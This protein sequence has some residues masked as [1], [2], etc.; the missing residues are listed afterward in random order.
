MNCNCAYG[1]PCQFNA[2]PT[3]R[4]C[5]AAVGLRIEKGIYGDVSLDSLTAGMAA[6]WPGPIHEGN[7]ERQI[8]IDEK[9]SPEQRAVSEKILSGDDTEPM[10]TIQ[11]FINAMT[12]TQ[13]LS[14]TPNL[15]V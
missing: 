9:A 6:K 1:C 2:L 3:T 4:T 15:A 11:W 13:H 8:I 10:A 7:G 12:S 5:E 14:D